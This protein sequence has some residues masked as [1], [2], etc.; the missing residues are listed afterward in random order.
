MYIENPPDSI[1]H[2]W[3]SGLFGWLEMSLGMHWANNSLSNWNDWDL[4]LLSAGVKHLQLYLLD[5]CRIPNDPLE[6]TLVLGM[7]SS[8]LVSKPQSNH[9]HI[10]SQKK[11]RLCSSWSS[12]KSYTN[13]LWLPLPHQS[14]H[15]PLEKRNGPAP[16]RPGSGSMCLETA[17]NIKRDIDMK[18]C[19]YT[20]IHI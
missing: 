4:W 7:I 1:P 12:Y 18:I 3:W 8:Q 13:Y 10:V 2:G 5:V 11:Y 17:V 15:L 6:N 20:I 14:K 19:K 16:N 9:C